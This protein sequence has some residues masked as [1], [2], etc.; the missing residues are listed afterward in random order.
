MKFLNIGSVH[1]ILLL[2]S[3]TRALFIG[4]MCAAVR[5]PDD[6]WY[7]NEAVTSCQNKGHINTF[8]KPA[9]KTQ[10]R[11]VKNATM[12]KLVEML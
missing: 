9:L 5:T 10:I 12:E 3:G 2:K 7:F 11:G 6:L 8:L 1:N 4:E